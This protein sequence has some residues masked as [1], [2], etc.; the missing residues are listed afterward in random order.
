[1][2]DTQQLAPGPNRRPACRR[3]LGRRRLLLLF[4]AGIV[5]VALQLP[6]LATA[7]AFVPHAAPHAGAWTLLGSQVSRPPNPIGLVDRIE[8]P[9]ALNPI[10]STIQTPT[11]AAVLLDPDPDTSTN[12]RGSSSSTRETWDAVAAPHGERGAAG[13][14][15]RGPGVCVFRPGAGK[16]GQVMY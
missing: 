13:P 6:S 12:H 4:P 8:C 11:A 3:L 16:G 2:N 15:E 7:T 10:T 9:P 1:M 14:T 5:A